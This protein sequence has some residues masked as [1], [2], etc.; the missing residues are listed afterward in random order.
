M[1]GFSFSS[2]V[3]VFLLIVFF[4]FPVL[5]PPREPPAVP[6][7]AGRGRDQPHQPHHAGADGGGGR[8]GRLWPRRFPPPPLIGGHRVVYR[9]H[10]GPAAPLPR[11]QAGTAQR[12]QSAKLSPVV[13]IGTPPTPSP[14]G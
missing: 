6:R 4:E 3:L 12:R 9:Q 5:I 7:R 10:G 14:A 1:N 11:R 2:L 8:R 13:G